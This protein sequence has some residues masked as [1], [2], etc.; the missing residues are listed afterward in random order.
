M[1]VKI[2]TDSSCDI[3]LDTLKEMGVD[4]IVI[5]VFFGEDE[6]LEGVNLTGESFYAM[7]SAAETLPKTAQITPV[8]FEE[9]IAPHIEAGDEV[10]ILPISKELSGTYNNALIAAA[11]FPEGRVHVVDTCHV[12]FSLA[13]MVYE[14]VALR[15]AGRTGAQIAA[16]MAELSP[17]IRLYAVI[18]D[19]KYLKLGGRL[20]SAGA[21]VGTLLGVKPLITISEG[22]VVNIAKARGLK[23]GYSFIADKVK[24]EADLSRRM[25]SGHSRCTD[26]MEE[27]LETCGPY[28]SGAVLHRCDI[29][30]VVGTHIGP[31]CTGVA[32]VEK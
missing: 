32:F 15:D 4:P 12:T 23:A 3:A 30:P 16:A 14:A 9:R 29:G 20:S 26:R 8:E 7:L 25:T 18:D 21:V 1:A 13:L 22:K 28:M 17:K 19:L 5:R 31:G 24:E 11:Q 27:M 6:Y 2:M 10:V